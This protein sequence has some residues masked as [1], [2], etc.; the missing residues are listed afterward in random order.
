MKIGVAMYG[1]N[2][3]KHNQDAGH[4]ATRREKKTE[5][6]KIMKE[7]L[8]DIVMSQAEVIESRIGFQIDEAGYR[9]E[10][11]NLKVT[12]YKIDGEDKEHYFIHTKDGASVNEFDVLE[13]DGEED[14]LDSAIKD[15]LTNWDSEWVEAFEAENII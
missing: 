3:Y 13:W 2:P 4:S 1:N 9:Q 10:T 6:K 12:V 7:I 15:S 14:S 5:G 11:Y 8:K